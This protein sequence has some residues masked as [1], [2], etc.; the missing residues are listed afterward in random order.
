LTLKL[1]IRFRIAN[2]ANVCADAGL[3]KL[4]IIIAANSKIPQTGIVLFNAVDKGKDYLMTATRPSG[5]A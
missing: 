4:T 2:S 1:D 3:T 5:S